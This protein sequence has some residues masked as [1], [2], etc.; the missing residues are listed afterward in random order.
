MK[1]WL[2]ARKHLRIVAEINIRRA[3]LGADSSFPM[4]AILLVWFSTSSLLGE[5]SLSQF[6]Y[7]NDDGK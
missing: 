1:T 2:L 6:L 7:Q 5:A 4:V 3:I